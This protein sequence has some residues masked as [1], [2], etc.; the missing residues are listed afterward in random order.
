[1]K[2]E[3]EQQEER[4]TEQSERS[5]YSPPQALRL[6]Q[7]AGGHGACTDG[8]SEAMGTCGTGP[9]AFSCDTGGAA[10][11]CPEGNEPQH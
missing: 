1:M 6:G 8:S 4:G 5:Q 11:N 7:V 2:R 9:S 10:G 3:S